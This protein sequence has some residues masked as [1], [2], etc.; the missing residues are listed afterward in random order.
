MNLVLIGM[1]LSGKNHDCQGTAVRTAGIC[2]SAIP[3]KKSTR[4]TNQSIE[5]LFRNQTAKPYFR[6]LETRLG[7]SQS[8]CFAARSFPPAAE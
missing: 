4:E 2:R 8:L 1:P 6:T 5:A 3:I 7:R